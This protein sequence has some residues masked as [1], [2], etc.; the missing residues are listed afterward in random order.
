MSPSPRRCC[1]ISGISVRPWPWRLKHEVSLGTWEGFRHRKYVVWWNL[2]HRKMIGS[3]LMHQSPNICFS[4]YFPTWLFRIPT[5]FSFHMFQSWLESDE[6]W[7][8]LQSPG[9]PFSLGQAML[10]QVESS[11][12]TLPENEGN[13]EIYR[14]TSGPSDAGCSHMQSRCSYTACSLRASV[15]KIQQFASPLVRFP[16][17]LC[18]LVLPFWVQFSGFASCQAALVVLACPNQQAGESCKA[19]AILRGYKRLGRSHCL[20]SSYVLRCCRITLE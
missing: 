12:R 15:Q 9:T 1:S 13:T 2:K 18:L 8:S 7:S 17:I 5:R 19:H 16:F 20:V 10:R 4:Y 3:K 6:I 11:Q 14:D